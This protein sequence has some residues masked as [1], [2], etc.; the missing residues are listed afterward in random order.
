MGFLMLSFGQK[1]VGGNSLDEH[2]FLSCEAQGTINAQLAK[3]YRAF[4]L[5]PDAPIEDILNDATHFLRLNQEVLLILI[6]TQ[7]RPD[8]ADLLEHHPV[9]D[10]LATPG[11]NKLN[12]LD[13]CQKRENDCLSLH[14]VMLLYGIPAMR[15]YAITPWVVNFLHK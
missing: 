5:L 11:N 4:I 12:A 10:Y 1:V 8:L 9:H 15:I 13:D 3:G 14:P 6:L 7:P 2:V